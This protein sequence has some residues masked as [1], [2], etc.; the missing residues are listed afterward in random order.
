MLKIENVENFADVN[1]VPKWTLNS[2]HMQRLSL[3]E[4]AFTVVAIS[5]LKIIQWRFR[6]HEK[7]T[8]DPIFFVPV[9]VNIIAVIKTGQFHLLLF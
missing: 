2:Q 6:N 9:H 8:F 7:F 4:A 5:H 1:K 3:W